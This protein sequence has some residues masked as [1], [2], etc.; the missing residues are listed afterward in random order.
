MWRCVK[1]YSV[2]VQDFIG[3]DQTSII[4]LEYSILDEADELESG[5]TITE[6][7]TAM[8][9]WARTQFDDVPDEE[10][11]RVFKAL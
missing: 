7:G 10:R 2:N 6:G 9:A 3:S 5:E 8:M 1:F 11:E 4:L